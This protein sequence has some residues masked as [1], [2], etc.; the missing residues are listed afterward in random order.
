MP[1]RLGPNQRSFWLFV[2]FAAVLVA[3]VGGL[4]Y[5][6]GSRAL[7][8]AV[9]VELQSLAIVKQARI[10][11]WL[12]GEVST[13]EAIA[14]SPA[15]AQ[16]TTHPLRAELQP[17]AWA[18]AR[19]AEG[20][21][22]CGRGGSGTHRIRTLALADPDS[23]RVIAATEDG[24]V[25]ATLADRREW[26][27][28]R[29]RSVVLGAWHPQLARQPVLALATPVRVAEGRP[30][31]VLVGWIDLDPLAAITEQ[32][33]GLR[34][35]DQFYL[36]DAE[37][38]YLTQPRLMA[39]P[40]RLQPAPRSEAVGRCLAGA[41]GTV[42]APDFRSVPALIAYR[43]LPV[44]G[45]CLIAQLDLAEA[46]APAHAFGADVLLLSPWL[47]LLAA[48]LALVLARPRAG[49]AGQLPADSARL[50]QLEHELL[51]AKQA[52]EQAGRARRGFLAK[53]S[54]EV[55]TPLNGV[56]G[57]VDL[58]LKTPLSDG[59]R[60]L[61]ALARASGETLVTAINDILR[62]AEHGVDQ[63]SSD[64]SS[65]RGDDG[66]GAESAPH[67][68]GVRVLLA[69]DNPTN[70]I[71]ARMMLRQ[72]GCSVEVAADGRDALRLLDAGDYDLV[73]LDCEM[74]GLDGFE[75]AAAIRQRGD[76]KAQLPIIA[77]TAQAM[78][79]DRERC[80]DA[81]MNDYLCKP[82]SEA[83]IAAVLQRWLP[84]PRP[85]QAVA[86]VAAAACAIDP[87]VIARLR[88]LARVTDP[89]LLD[90]ILDAFRSDGGQHIAALRAAATADDAGA[91]RAA[92][93]LLKGA[94]GAVGAHALAEKAQQVYALG[95]AGSMP[96]ASAAIEG[97]AE[98]FARAIEEIDR[99]DPPDA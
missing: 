11:A 13:I 60:E 19:V 82:V 92:A 39:T 94:S 25:G 41:D 24:M 83:A 28:G 68:P 15:L 51:Q 4:G 10:S 88:E 77:V 59:Q 55:R 62:F 48:A 56:M 90:Q 80:L 72:L 22:W 5:R 97:L 52:A 17:G 38:R 36:V 63:P 30:A 37:G 65:S 7:G 8:D 16:A 84:S 35:S 9:G 57:T 79:G 6:L 75:T 71:V 87:A 64:L 95:Q 98:E 91:L 45:L 29:Q 31:G 50:E 74:P 69:E 34:R 54:H 14:A 12:A 78:A 73:L 43:H 89:A 66:A 21:V 58:L 32:R 47:L 85:V 93:H 3:A 2:S 53:V 70:Q 23:G 61:V 26:Q 20:A 49:H 40:V 96:A 99:L 27:D 46:L 42:Q 1:I 86:P 67:F 76:G 81:G 44:Q 33:S 18:A